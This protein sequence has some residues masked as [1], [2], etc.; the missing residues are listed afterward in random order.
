[1]T[2]K[3]EDQMNMLEAS[4]EVIQERGAQFQKWGIQNRTPDEWMLIF[5]EE[6]GE[7]SQAVLDARYAGA[8]PAEIKKELVQVAAVALAMLE[9]CN[10]SKWHE[11]T[12]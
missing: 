2:M 4:S 9:N 11:P 5:M 8:D 6:V 10:S 12:P 3:H 1:M 7:F